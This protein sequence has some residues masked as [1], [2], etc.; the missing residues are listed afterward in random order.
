M[1]L[2]KFRP[3]I[4]ETGIVPCVILIGTTFTVYLQFGPVIDDTRILLPKILNFITV[5]EKKII[6]ML[7]Y[8]KVQTNNSCLFLWT[9]RF[10]PLY[11]V[12]GLHTVRNL[13]L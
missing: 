5:R 10:G 7:V 12:V 4:G 6:L 3:S 1:K 9:I 11:F 13:P 8:F 2:N